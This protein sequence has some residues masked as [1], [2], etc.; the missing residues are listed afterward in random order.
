MFLDQPSRKLTL[1]ALQDYALSEEQS[2]RQFIIVTPNDLHGMIRGKD[3]RHAMLAAP[4]RRFGS[5]N[6]PVQLTLDETFN[7]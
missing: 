6:A 5:A 4:E 3:V 7:T 2:G 1:V